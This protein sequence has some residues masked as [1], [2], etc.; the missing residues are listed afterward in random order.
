[1]SYGDYTVL[2]ADVRILRETLAKLARFGHPLVARV[3]SVALTKYAAQIKQ[4][5]QHPEKVFLP[6]ENRD[7]CL[8]C[9]NRS[10]PEVAQLNLGGENAALIPPPAVL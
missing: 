10:L 6:T 7:A 2:H 8:D 3:A 5:C 4:Y 9:G 1:M